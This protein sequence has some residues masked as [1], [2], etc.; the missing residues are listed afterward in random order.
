MPPRHDTSHRPSTV[1]D[2]LE[3]ARA[4]LRRVPATEAF[5]RH[6]AGALLVDVRTDAQRQADGGIP[7][8]LEIA[9]SHLEWRLDPCSE[10]RIPE[11]CDHDVDVIVLCAQGYASSLAAARLQDLG[12]HRATDVVDGFEAWCAA[13]LPV[14][15]V[16]R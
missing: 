8:A 7:G 6:R 3:A 11:A 16:E 14:R 9:L 4:R 5:A 13:G 2:L 10:H 15:R 12:L 1:D